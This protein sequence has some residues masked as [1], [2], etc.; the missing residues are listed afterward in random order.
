MGDIYRVLGRTREAEQFYLRALS[1]GEKSAGVNS[2]EHPN[3]AQ[4][5]SNL[6]APYCLGGWFTD[7]EA[8]FQRALAV[9]ESVLGKQSASVAKILAEY[10]VLLRK[11]RQNHRAHALE[12]RVQEIRKDHAPEDLIW[13]TI[14]FSDLL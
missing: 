5:L 4:T 9:A 6:G 14:E 11:T 7:V 2:P 8:Q 13:H 1:A 10:A 12:R 3:V